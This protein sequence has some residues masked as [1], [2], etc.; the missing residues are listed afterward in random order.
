MSAVEL[1]G[2]AVSAL[3]LSVPGIGLWYASVDMADAVPL[4]GSVTLRV[5]DVSYEGFVIS[6]GVVDGRAQYRIVA[7]AGGW[8][9]E[10][11]P[12]AYAN[13][14]GVTAA[15]VLT[16]AAA[17]AG[18][19]LVAAP[20]TTR[21]GVHFNRPRLPASFV[22]NLL[23]PRS[24]WAGRTGVIAFGPRPELPAPALDTVA[25]NPAALLVELAAVDTLAGVVPGCSTEYG[26]CSDLE[27]EL[28][29]SGIRARLYASAAQSRRVQ[30]YV[31]LLD[32]SDPG[33][34]FRGVFEYRI[35]S[36]TAERLNLQPVRSRSDMPDLA[37]VPVR[38]GV[39]G[40]RAEHSPGSQVLVA[41]LDADPSRPA[42]VGFDD[43]GQPGWMPLS[44]EL[45]GPG[46]LGVA[47][48]T[49]TVQAGAFAGVITSAS[50]RV[51]AVI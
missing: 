42:V 17:E 44:L 39:P 6:G 20:P 35:V 32:A 51:K 34:R 7:G 2:N 15:R 48:I 28:D 13:D 49:D 43:P 18:E 26:P 50:L 5:L 24:W 9:R 29:S 8:G 36:Q 23:A 46:A 47:R 21:L 33:R 40:V 12:K 31:R 30:A 37:R 1:N 3:T 38:A 10:L 27:V 41:F 16:D 45:G 11:P 22:L 19:A 25:R 4:A 14:A